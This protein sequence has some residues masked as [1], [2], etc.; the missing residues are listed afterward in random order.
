MI[1]AKETIEDK[2]KRAE[3]VAETRLQVIEWLAKELVAHKSIPVAWDGE[4]VCSHVP[5]EWCD[6]DCAQCWIT[7]AEM[8]VS[9][10]TGQGHHRSAPRV[11]S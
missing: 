6:H 7:A 5:D 1:N 8:A 3:D 4:T 9:D 11:A 2:L 10:S